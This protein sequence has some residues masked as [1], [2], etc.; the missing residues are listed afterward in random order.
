M[1]VA[2]IIDGDLGHQDGVAACHFAGGLER[3]SQLIQ[4]LE[5]LQDQQV[6]AF[7]HQGFNLLTKHGAGLFQGGWT[8]RLQQHTQGTERAR[9]EDIRAFFRRLARQTHA[10]GVDV[11][12]LVRN[13]EVG[14]A[15]PVRAEGVGFQNFGAVAHVVLVDIADERRA[16][17]I[18]LVVAAVNKDALRIENGSHGPIG[19]ECTFPQQLPEFAGAADSLLHY[20]PL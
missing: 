4:M 12:H 13:T 18:Q 14:Q 20:H 3:L 1:Q 19:D 16:G 8:Q 5:G 7:F 2:F 17:Q 10:G 11:R 6:H 15:Q 9:N